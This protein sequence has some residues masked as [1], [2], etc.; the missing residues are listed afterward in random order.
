M[1]RRDLLK[2]AGLA[3]LA[4]L[5]PS[6]AY[7][8]QSHSSANVEDT[9]REV[10]R[11]SKDGHDLILIKDINSLTLYHD[12]IGSLSLAVKRYDFGRD[13]LSSNVGCYRLGLTGDNEVT[14]LQ[15]G[16]KVVAFL[17]NNHREL[18]F[19]HGGSEYKG[20]SL[21]IGNAQLDRGSR[22][23]AGGAECQ[24]D[25]FIGGDRFQVKTYE[26]GEQFPALLPKPQVED[27]V[28]PLTRIYAQ[29]K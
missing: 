11:L 29:L 3:G 1:D 6:K 18:V 5:I 26:W 16:D 27:I 9:L 12:Q 15:L 20:N 17:S 24:F 4:A 10:A 25:L 23:L 22:P 7:A 19:N 8:S 14:A 13:N 28:S 2:T 21:L